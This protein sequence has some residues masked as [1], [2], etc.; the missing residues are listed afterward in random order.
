MNKRIGYLIILSA[1]ALTD[2]AFAISKQSENALSAF[3][4]YES[5][6]TSALRKQKDLDKKLSAIDIEKDADKASDIWCKAETIMGDVQDRYDNLE[7]MYNKAYNKNPGD[8]EELKEGFDR[9]ENLYRTVRDFY[10]D[11]FTYRSEDTNEKSE[12][13]EISTSSA[14]LNEAAELVPALAADDNKDIV[15]EGEGGKRKRRN[16]SVGGSLKIDHRNSDEIHQTIGKGGTVPNDQTQGRLVLNYELDENRTWTLEDRYLTRERNEKNKEN[17]LTLSYMGKH[18][19]GSAITFRD[20][21]QHIWYPDNTKK[22]YRNNTFETLYAKSW[23]NRER[24]ANIGFKTQ[25]YSHSSS[26]DYKQYLLGESETWLRRDG[27]IFAEYKGEFSRYNHSG[28]LDYD[29][30]NIY[31]EL[32]KTFGGNKANLYIANT[33]DRRLYDHESAVAYRSSYYDD[34][35]Q[36]NY[37]LPVNEKVNYTFEGSY[38]KRNYSADRPRGYAELNIFNGVSVQTDRR[39]VVSGDYRYVYNDENTRDYAHKNHIFHVGWNRNFNKSYRLRIE[40]TYQDRN[41]VQNKRLDFKQNTASAEFMWKLQGKYNLTWNTTHFNRSYDSISLGTADYRYLESGF[42]LSYS[43]RK[44][45]DW[46]ISQSWR[47]MEHRN[48]GGIVTGWEKRV[49]PITELKY[50]RW[51]RDDVKFGI[52][53]TWEKTYYHDFNSESQEMEYNF[54]DLI[55]NKEFYVSL[56]YLF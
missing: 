21:L 5:E 22:S 12:T 43:K 11:K 52:R 6:F 10:A 19:D 9:L 48:W 15:A 4:R 35:F 53:A 33:Y 31:A 20:K 51:L 7:S 34:Y 24:T 18:G 46:R 50:N 30:H 39:T 16:F 38:D 14:S 56:E 27:Q 28:K 29:N 47:N 40:D 25:T 32:D 2:P 26:S 13:E 49:Q 54:G 23:K 44:S 17:H 3:R 42:E 55:Y 41:S 1:L 37:N 8:R 36:L 45:Y